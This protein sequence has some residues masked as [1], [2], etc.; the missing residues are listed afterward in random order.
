[1]DGVSGYPP[2]NSQPEKIAAAAQMSLPSTSIFGPL[3]TGASI[4]RGV[5]SGCASA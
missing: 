5:A 3:R 1:M 2:K 4:V